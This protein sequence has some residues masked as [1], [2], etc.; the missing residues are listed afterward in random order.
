MVVATQPANHVIP[1]NIQPTNQQLGVKRDDA[2]RSTSNLEDIVEQIA[3]K[4]ANSGNHVEMLQ[5]LQDC[6]EKS[7]DSTVC[8]RPHHKLLRTENS[9]P[10]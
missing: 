10:V 1:Q 2:R 6:V 8:K 9:S 4:C 7:R 3:I 5:C